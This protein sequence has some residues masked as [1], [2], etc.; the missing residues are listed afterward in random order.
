LAA[1]QQEILHFLAQPCPESAPLVKSSLFPPDRTPSL[2]ICIG[3]VDIEQITGLRLQLPASTFLFW[4]HPPIPPDSAAVLRNHPAIRDTRTLFCALDCDADFCSKVG[5]IISTLP[6]P[7]VHLIASHD[8]RKE[9]EKEIED[10][11]QAI[12]TALDNLNQDI[13]RGMIRL[14]CSIRNLP[15]ILRHSPFRLKSLPPG[16]SCLI[17]GAGPSLGSQVDRIREASHGMTLIAVGHAVP[18]LLHAGIRPDVVVEDDCQASRNWPP[19]LTTDSLLVSCFDVSPEVARRFDRILWCE[20]NSHPFR[21]LISRWQ[22]PHRQL[23]LDKTVTVHALDFARQA[24][25]SNLA[26]VGQDLSVPQNGQLH[27]DGNRIDKADQLQKIMGNEGHSVLATRDL[28]ELRKAIETYL[29]SL[30]KA[31]AGQDKVAVFN[32]THGGAYIQGTQRMALDE[33]C[34]RYAGKTPKPSITE[35]ASFPIPDIQADIE[36]LVSSLRSYAEVAMAI[37]TICAELRGEIESKQLNMTRIRQRQVGLQALMQKEQQC[38]AAENGFLLNVLIHFVDTIMKETPG[39]ITAENDPILQMNLLDSRFLFAAEL[40]GDIGSDLAAVTSLLQQ[41]RDEQTVPSEIDGDAYSFPSFRRQAL[42]FIRRNNPELA[43]YLENQRP[44]LPP[45]K[46]RIS[47][48][49]QFI[50]YVQVRRSTGEWQANSGFFSMYERASADIETFLGRTGFDARCHALI[51]TEPCNWIHV[52][53]F[54]RRQPDAE[55]IVLDPW[56][57]LLSALIDRG[58]FLHRLNPHT[59]IIGLHPDLRDG[60]ELASR[61]LAEWKERGLTPLPFPCMPDGK[62]PETTTALRGLGIASS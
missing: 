51:F 8:I 49:N 11:N 53:E 10:V 23:R 9:F 42:R 48:I 55:V 34:V 52:I 6:D 36:C 58:V 33:F 29:A 59:L 13:S 46:F 61:R 21:V 31:D 54:A 32:C 18:A 12:R 14:R 16:E 1:F 35:T 2:L 19:G 27:I 41:P 28:I 56:S 62:E 5:I 30:D 43:S 47:W 25:F 17:C 38:R 15:S 24:G 39:L 26:L 57:E 3:A 60:A 50:P 20:G 4:L 45:D 22:I 37:S 40:C 44:P 7:R